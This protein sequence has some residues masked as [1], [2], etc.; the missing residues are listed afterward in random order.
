MAD[1]PPPAEVTPGLRGTAQAERV[2]SRVTPNFPLRLQSG[3]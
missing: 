1:S 2:E 3:R